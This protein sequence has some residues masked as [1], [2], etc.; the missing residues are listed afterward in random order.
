[1]FNGASQLAYSVLS[2]VRDSLT[3]VALLF[4]LLWLNWQLTLVTIL[5]LLLFGGA[6]GYAFRTLRPLFR[7]RGKITAEVTGRLTES[8][9]GVRVIKGY[10]AEKRESD[11][12]VAGVQRILNN[13]LQ[14][15]TATSTMGL[16]ATLLMGVVG[17]IVMFVG[18][19][20]IMAGHMQLGDLVA[21]KIGS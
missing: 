3:A 1:M 21:F 2:L 17:A 13:I 19:R 14:T 20:Q 18:A 7:E 5:V 15:L 8:L 16:V 9:G 4:Y 11:V 12:F 6:M 10:H